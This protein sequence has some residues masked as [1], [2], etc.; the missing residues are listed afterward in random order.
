MRWT[1]LRTIRR[2]I[3]TCRRSGAPIHGSELKVEA[4]PQ[5]WYYSNL[6]FHEGSKA[7]LSIFEIL[8]VFGNNFATMDFVAGSLGIIDL[9]IKC[10]IVNQASSDK[11]C[12]SYQ[13]GT[14]VWKEA[15]RDVS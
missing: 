11:S 1:R 7:L 13:H 10:V 8:R 12:Q 5:I 14:Q 9:C 2:P 3:R 6:R 4:N 15:H